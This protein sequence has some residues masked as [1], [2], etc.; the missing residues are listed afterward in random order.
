MTFAYFDTSVLVKNYVAEAGS[1][2]ARAL[3]KTHAFLSSA[4][5]PVEL[6]SALMRRRSRGE[7]EAH[8]LPG[9]LARVREDRSYWKLLDVGPAVLIRG[10]ELMQKT[11]MRT[12]DAIHVASAMTFEAGSGMQVPFITGDGQQR[13]AAA[14]LGLAVVWVG[15]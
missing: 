3:L 14:R 9:I 13:D 12:L 10:E 1:A 4:I 8:D 15:T 6:I 2:R 11:R 5:S 7:L